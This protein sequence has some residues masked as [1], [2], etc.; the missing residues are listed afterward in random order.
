MERRYSEM[1]DLISLTILCRAITGLHNDG[2]KPL[3]RDDKS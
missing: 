3:I 2:K 1:K